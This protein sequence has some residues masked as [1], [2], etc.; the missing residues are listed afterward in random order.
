[1]SEVE[2]KTHPLVFP[3]SPIDIIGLFV[4]II[5]ERFA[6]NGPEFPWKWDKD[7]TLSK[8]FI[9]AG[10]VDTYGNNDARPAIYVDRSSLVYSK[11]ALNNLA[12]YSLRNSSRSYTCKVSG[13]VAI[14]CIS[15]NR[16]ES[17]ILSDI[18]ASHLVM[19]DDLFRKVYNFQDIGP[20]S[21]GNTETWEK[22]DRVFISRVQCEFT[23]DI[24]WTYTP[25][26]NRVE[27]INGLILP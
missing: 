20:V 2:V 9:D 1:M 12:D 21:L 25:D 6:F 17:T 27:R 4:A 10:G 15:K 14:D 3:K 5:R 7:D 8:V 11:V 23:H 18:A 26:V 16:G 24:F 13:Q 19:S 22:D